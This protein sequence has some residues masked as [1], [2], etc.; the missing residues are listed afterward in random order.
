MCSAPAVVPMIAD[1]N[2]IVGPSTP[3][4]GAIMVMPRPAA[5]VPFTNCLRVMLLMFCL[6]LVDDREDSAGTGGGNAVACGD[7]RPGTPTG[8]SVSA[9]TMAVDTPAQENARLYRAGSI[10]RDTGGALGGFDRVV[11]QHR[12]GHRPDA[13]RDRG[14]ER[15]LLLHRLEIHVAD[16][17]DMPFCLSGVLHAIHADVDHDG[18]VLHHVRDDVLGCPAAAM[19]MSAW[20][21]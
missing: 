11:E 15:S 9:R 5:T 2:L 13:A 21:V 8:E 19:R 20:R 7:R 4:V 16:Q 3:A 10:R 6:L 18:P 14:D 12:D 17:S 1:P